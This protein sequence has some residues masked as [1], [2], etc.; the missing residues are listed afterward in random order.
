[1]KSIFVNF[2]NFRASSDE[3]E[4]KEA[5]CGEDAHEADYEDDDD[6]ESD[7]ESSDSDSGNRKKTVPPKVPA[8]RWS[9][10]KKRKDEES[11]EEETST[12]VDS[13]DE[14]TSSDDDS[15]SSSE[16]S[17]SEFSSGTNTECEF[18]DSEGKPN[19]FHKELEV[20][21]IVIE[22]GSPLA[23]TRRNVESNKYF[24]APKYV[25][26]KIGLETREK[27]EPSL[28]SLTYAS[29][30]QYKTPNLSGRLQSEETRQAG[31]VTRS[32]QRALSL[33]KNWVS[34]APANMATGKKSDT[35]EMDSRLKSL[36]ER[37][38][39]Q[40]SL[41]KPADKP[42]SQMEHLLKNSPSSRVILS[43]ST[44]SLR[45]PARFKSPPPSSQ[46]GGM[47]AGTGMTSY[48][49]YPSHTYATASTTATATT[50]TITPVVSAPSLLRPAI[51]PV[52]EE[53]EKPEVK[54]EEV[55]PPGF[56]EVERIQ[57]PEQQQSED[58][59]VQLMSSC[60][61]SSSEESE[62]LSSSESTQSENLS[63]VP[64]P[65]P[66]APLMVPDI[67]IHSDV[68]EKEV[69]ENDEIVANKEEINESGRDEFESCL[70]ELECGGGDGG[71]D[72][73][74]TYHTPGKEVETPERPA[75]PSPGDILSPPL[76]TSSPLSQTPE[77]E[78][79][80]VKVGV[81]IN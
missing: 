24:P 40:Q 60:N 6:S 64:P 81:F 2:F 56:T 7:S 39:N 74:N 63:P 79:V 12:E 66:P 20:P 3:D 18:T 70:E 38:S 44:S 43:Q 25:E 30:L 73:S 62:D 4:C 80:V 34:D 75:E 78:Q 59:K 65:I 77:K 41:L 46:G 48:H 51:E 27:S 22:P 15:S 49:C 14:S 21:K 8:R 42:S 29:R 54:V 17:E 13:D 52:Q 68:E 32:T 16:S 11:E 67:L 61:S 58:T 33:K 36:M 57:V 76:A 9:R 53:V 1:M 19:P 71:E 31:Y 72:K 55:A 26:Q 10:Q 35:A 47:T 28:S 5:E 45:D 37:L 50:A 69:K 23:S